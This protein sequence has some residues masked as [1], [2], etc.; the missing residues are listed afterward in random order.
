MKNPRF[1]GKSTGSPPK[2]NQNLF[3]VSKV[4]LAG[5]GMVEENHPEIGEV[6]VELRRSLLTW[7][8]F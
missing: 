7:S 3:P 4:G 5:T 6:A 8:R 2:N 1:I